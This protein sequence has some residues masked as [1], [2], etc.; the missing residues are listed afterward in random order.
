MFNQILPT[1]YHEE[2]VE[3]SEENLHVD[4]GVLRVQW[5]HVTG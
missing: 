1:K 2:Y 3:N 5:G 4:A